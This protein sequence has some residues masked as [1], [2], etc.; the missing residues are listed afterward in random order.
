MMSAQRSWRRPL[1]IRRSAT[2]APCLAARRPAPLY[3]SCWMSR[4]DGDLGCHPS[5]GT[6]FWLCTG[7][8]FAEQISFVAG[9]FTLRFRVTLG[10]EQRACLPVTSTRLRVARCVRRAR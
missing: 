6:T 1:L 5:R 8:R 7:R 3:S 9:V 10:G 4:P 2:A